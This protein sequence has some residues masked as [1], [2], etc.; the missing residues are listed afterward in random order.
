MSTRSPGEH[1]EAMSQRVTEPL[2]RRHAELRK[3]IDLIAETAER[4]PGL[5]PAER[6]RAVD[7]VLAFLREELQLHAEAEELWLYP[8]VT[9]RLHHPRAIAVMEFDHLLLREYVDRLA[10]ADLEDEDVLQEAL[11]GLSALLDAHFRKEE[12]I[13]LPLLEDEKEAA[14]VRAV[15]H[16]MAIHEHLVPPD[17][18]AMRPVD[19]DVREFP[20][21][22]R[23]AE[24]LAY[25][26]RY[27]V[28][29]PSSHNSQPWLFKLAGDALYLY[30][31]RTRALAVV[32]PDDRE[33]VM[34]CGAALFH[35]RT[36]ARHYDY[37]TE[38]EL[39]PDPADPDLLARIELGEPRPATYEEKLL[40]WAIAKRHTNRHAFEPR[41]LPPELTHELE[42]ATAAEGAWL[43]HVAREEAREALGDLVAAAD[44]RQLD[45]GRFRRELAAWIHPNRSEAR[46]G[47]PAYALGIPALLSGV[48]P[49]V[50][51]TFDVGRGIAARDRKL[52]DGSPSLFVLVTE[53]D[54]TADWLRAGQALD[55]VLLRAAQ[56]EVSA[57]FLNQPVEVPDLRPSV[58]ALSGRDGFAQTVLRM[59]YG[60]P[61]Q[62]TPRRPTAE[63]L[64]Q[65][66]ARTDA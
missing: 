50:V 59:G 53:E 23:P 10:T 63:V 6:Q 19:P 8:Q 42:A 35:L 4:I 15:E 65:E 27:A 21:G 26:L 22:G 16:A 1:T 12:E 38:V 34:S 43:A 52:L 58:A 64:V 45:D 31:D 49:F 60:P 20:E 36:A 39:L 7:E 56:E 41:P 48:G 33:L 3:G 24:K 62:A 57:S 51:R 17:P 29:A 37:E 66:G 40:F 2:R 54:G 47:M 55:R 18:E 14:T 32:D 61:A 28:R 30:A 44:L 46:D 9:R 5:D 13:Y 11:Y 25:L